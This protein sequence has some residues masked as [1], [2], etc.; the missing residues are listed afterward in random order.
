MQRES[1]IPARVLFNGSLLRW[2]SARLPLSV[3]FRPHAR[4]GEPALCHLLSD[5]IYLFLL[6]LLFH[7]LFSYH[8]ISPRRETYY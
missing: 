6:P 7:F 1:V 2:F 8:M 5:F 3:S 4:A